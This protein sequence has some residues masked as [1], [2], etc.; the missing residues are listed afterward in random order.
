MV[1]VGIR[2]FKDANRHRKGLGLSSG[3]K[4]NNKIKKKFE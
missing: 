3:Y 2:N 1:V 4:V